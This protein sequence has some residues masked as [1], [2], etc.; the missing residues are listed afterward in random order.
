MLTYCTRKITRAKHLEHKYITVRSFKNYTQEKFIQTLISVEFPDYSTFQ[1][2]EES[3]ND[4]IFKLTDVI[5]KI[6]PIKK[7]RVKGNTQDWF[8]DEIH[9]AIKQRDKLFSTFKNTRLNN[10]NLS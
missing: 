7:V 6:A 2:V 10:D 5:N 1:T 3:Y 8:D 9:Q 4:F